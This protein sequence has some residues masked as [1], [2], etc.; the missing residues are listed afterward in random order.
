MFLMK[1]N[2]NNVKIGGVKR[3]GRNRVSVEFVTHQDANSFLVNGMVAQSYVTSIPQFNITRMGIVRDV[4]VEW[5][6]N[7]I[8]SNI[9]VP[10]ACGAVIKARRM[11]R[12]VSTTNGTEWK[13]TQTEVLTFD[14]QT[15]LK[16]VFC[17]SS[18]LPVELYSYPTIQCYHCCRFGHTRTICRSKPRCFK[19]GQDH[20]GDGCQIPAETATCVN[21]SG[22]HFAN[23]KACPELGRQ[24]SIKA[25]M[26][27]KSISYAEASQVFPTVKRSYA[28]VSRSVNLIDPSPIK[29]PSQQKSPIKKTMHLKP[30]SHAPL[31]PSHDKKT[32]QALTQD[33]C[34]SPSKNGC[35]FPVESGTNI[36]SSKYILNI[37]SDMLMA[38]LS[39]PAQTVP[40]HV[41]HKLSTIL[42]YICKIPTSK[43]PRALG[44]LA[45]QPGCG[46]Q[47]ICAASYNSQSTTS[48]DPSVEQY[49]RGRTYNYCLPIS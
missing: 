2:I 17:S 20:P 1:L 29:K 5:T 44:S 7:E 3:L 10:A 31:S 37:V 18:A 39:I 12:K 15:L 16:K 13:P 27:E 48:L 46:S 43:G 42:D 30:K 49:G 21:C 4:P 8:I 33:H 40:D 19:C 36:R 24:K 14:G 45:A 25:L 9:R 23:N 6:E 11:N 38:I 22:T 41:A 34:Y 47:N 35:A 26:A 28:E 32:H